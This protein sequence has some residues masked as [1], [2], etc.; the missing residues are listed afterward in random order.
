MSIEPDFGADAP[1]GAASIATIP[2]WPISIAYFDRKS[3]ADSAPLYVTSYTLYENGMAGHLKIAYADFSLVGTLTS[4][5]IL[6][7]PPCP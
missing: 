7:G 5:D 3:S 1:I 6:P 4:L 2:H